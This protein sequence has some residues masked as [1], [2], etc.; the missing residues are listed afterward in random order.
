MITNEDIFRL[1]AEYEKETGLK[2]DYLSDS[3]ITYTNW[4]E[5]RIVKLLTIPDVSGSALPKYDCD[6][7]RHYPCQTEPDSHGSQQRKIE[8]GKCGDHS[9]RSD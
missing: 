7:C 2:V 1:R 5:K 9:K 4:L 8:Y 6:D 3:I